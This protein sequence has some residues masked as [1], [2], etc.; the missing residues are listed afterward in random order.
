MF[1]RNKYSFRLPPTGNLIKIRET[2]IL[3]NPQGKPEKKKKKGV[4]NKNKKDQTAKPCGNWNVGL[5][6]MQVVTLFPQLPGLHPCSLSLPFSF[7]LLPRMGS[8]RYV[9]PSTSTTNKLPLNVSPSLIP[10]KRKTGNQCYC[11]GRL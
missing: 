4:L 11:E 2:G 5:M 10:T 8:L 3:A 9:F 6:R 7:Q 1:G